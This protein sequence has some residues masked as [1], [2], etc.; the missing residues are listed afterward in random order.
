MFAFPEMF[1]SAAEAVKIKVPKDTDNYDPN[2]CPHWAVFTRACFGQPMPYPGC[3][4]DNAK[5]IAQ[6]PEDKIKEVT[7]DQLIENGL[8]IGSSKIRQ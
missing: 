4:F 7:F 2:E 6:I 5:V 1:R 8:A 3:H